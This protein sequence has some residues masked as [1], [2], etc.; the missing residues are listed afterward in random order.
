MVSFFVRPEVMTGLYSLAAYATG[1]HLSVVSPFAAGC[2]SIIAWP[3]VYQQ[4][5]E[6]KAVIGG[7][8]PSARK[9]LKTDEL[10]FSAPLPLYVKMLDVM[11]KSA[12][13]RTTWQ[14]VRKKAERSRRA[15]GSGL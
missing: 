10:I 15:W 2:G 8:D 14:G 5:G 6:E 4:R 7:F 12:L 3:L 13:I 11:E 9:F 1:S